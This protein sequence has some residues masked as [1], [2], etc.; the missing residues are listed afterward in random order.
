MRLPRRNLVHVASPTLVQQN[1][2]AGHPVPVVDQLATSQQMAYGGAPYHESIPGRERTD[3]VGGNDENQ[4]RDSDQQNDGSHSELSGDLNT[5]D[6]DECPMDSK[7]HVV[8][9]MV[10]LSS[11]QWALLRKPTWGRNVWVL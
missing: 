11:R 3:D 2:F 8:R 4:A 5:D 6:K 1:A 9:R 7:Y 10:P